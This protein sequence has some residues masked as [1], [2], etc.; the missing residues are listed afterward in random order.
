MNKYIV[1]LAA[2]KRYPHEVPTLQG[3][4]QGLR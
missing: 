2:G 4:T 1:I 3:I